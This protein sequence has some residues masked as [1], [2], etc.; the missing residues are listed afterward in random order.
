VALVISIELGDFIT[1]PRISPKKRRKGGRLKRYRRRF[2]MMRILWKRWEEIW[3][4][5]VLGWPTTCKRRLAPKASCS[6][7]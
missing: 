6:K 7:R 1:L 4:L 2:K 3:V 5:L